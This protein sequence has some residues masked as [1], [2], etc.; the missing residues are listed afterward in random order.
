[1]ELGLWR[2]RRK[3]DWVYVGFMVVHLLASVLIDSQAFLPSSL[4]P[5]YLVEVKQDYLKQ[6]NDHIVGQLATP[7]MAWF[8]MTVILELAW[9]VPSF[10]LGIYGLVRDDWRI[11]PILIAYAS[12]AFST[13][14]IALWH[15]FHGPGS[16]SLSPANT[17]FLLQNYVPFTLIPF[18]MLIDFSNRCMSVLSHSQK[19]S[20]HDRAAMTDR[21]TR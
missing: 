20:Q 19:L 21:K 14:L 18:V 16:V 11:W 13:T 17:A 12:L 8:Y 5:K 3:L 2:H 4:V 7:E 6:S 9:Q 1:M 10:I 15:L